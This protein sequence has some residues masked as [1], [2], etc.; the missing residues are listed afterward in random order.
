MGFIRVRVINNEGNK[1][2]S[3]PK[4][5]EK[6]YPHYM[7]FEIKNEITPETKFNKIDNFLY[8]VMCN[9]FNSRYK[10][11][12]RKF[13]NEEKQKN[14]EL[15]G[16]CLNELMSVKKSSDIFSTKFV[17]YDRVPSDPQKAEIISDVKLS[18]NDTLVT[19]YQR[20]N[21]ERRRTS[22]TSV[23][24]KESEELCSK[25]PKL[26]CEDIIKMWLN[27]SRRNGEMLGFNLEFK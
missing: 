15:L 22:I 5:F 19:L 14:Y 2:K 1:Y 25:N 7:E 24:T 11:G 6:R 12:K 16:A 26:T 23:D 3:I 27:N 9:F 10:A 8:S 20:N 18:N 17:T 13:D 21:E 4:Y